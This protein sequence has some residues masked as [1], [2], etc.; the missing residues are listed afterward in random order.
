LF[1][2]F[3]TKFLC[4]NIGREEGHRNDL[5]CVELDVKTRQNRLRRRRR[6]QFVPFVCGLLYFTYLLRRKLELGERY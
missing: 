5:F 4:Q 6:N 2:F 3:S 1:S